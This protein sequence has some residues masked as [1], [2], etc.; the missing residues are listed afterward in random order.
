M[1]HSTDQCIPLLVPSFCCT[2]VY[3]R[4]EFGDRSYLRPKSAAVML[5]YGSITL[6][7]V[8]TEARSSLIRELEL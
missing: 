6:Q 2:N 4:C 8:Q 3:I 5:I 7:L 1:L